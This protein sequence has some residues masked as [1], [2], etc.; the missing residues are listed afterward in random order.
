[1]GSMSGSS[2]P[3]GS[4]HHGHRVIIFAETE[5]EVVEEVGSDAGEIVLRETKLVLDLVE[6]ATL[7]V[8]TGGIYGGYLGHCGQNTR[9][10]DSG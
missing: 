6:D 8:R 2:S 9:Q 4:I 7:D 1:M 10:R 5:F 3:R